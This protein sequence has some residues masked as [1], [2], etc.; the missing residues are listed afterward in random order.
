MSLCHEE[1]DVMKP[2]RWVVSWYTNNGIVLLC[3]KKGDPSVLT[4]RRISNL[5]IWFLQRWR[6]IPTGLQGWAS[7]TKWWSFIIIIHLLSNVAIWL[8]F[9]SLPLNV[10]VCCSF[11]LYIALCNFRLMRFQMEPSNCQI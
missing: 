10:Y 9:S 7:T 11:M 2:S 1:V 6:V 4:W 8:M 3:P 5:V